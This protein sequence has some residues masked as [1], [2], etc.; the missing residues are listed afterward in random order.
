VRGGT[1]YSGAASGS[2]HLVLSANP[3]NTPKIPP[4]GI[5][6]E[7]FDAWLGSNT[8]KTLKKWIVGPSRKNS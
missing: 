4:T 1:K 6:D 2:F 7:M 3:Q 5:R 8:Q